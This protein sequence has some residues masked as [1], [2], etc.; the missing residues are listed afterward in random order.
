MRLR[1]LP[2]RSALLA[3]VT[4]GLGACES[5][6]DAPRRV[7]KDIFAIEVPS[8][9]QATDT[10]KIGFGYQIDCGPRPTVDVQIGSAAVTVAVWQA[11]TNEGLVCPAIFSSASTEILL[12]PGS[13][14]AGAIEVRFRQ[15]SGPDSVRVVTTLSASAHAP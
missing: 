9:L 13:R 4:L 11:V 10:L 12:P 8:T 7:Y 15:A 3:L 1:S 6:T 14:A 2:S 5:P